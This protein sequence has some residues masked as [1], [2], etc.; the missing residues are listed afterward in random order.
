MSIGTSGTITQ[1]FSDRLTASL[2]MEPS[3]EC[4]FAMLAGAARAGAMGL[5]AAAQRAGGTGANM[6]EAMGNAMGSLRMLDPRL[7]SIAR[8]FTRVVIDPSAAMPGKVI[9]VNRP[10]FVSGTMTEVARRLTEGNQISATPISPSWAQLPLTVREYG[11]VHNGTDAVA[12]IGVSSFLVDRAAHDQL[13][14][15][16]FILRRDFNSWVDHVFSDLLLTSTN[17]EFA[18]TADGSAATDLASGDTFTDVEIRRGVRFMR[19]R[20]IPPFS[21]TGRYLLFITPRI[22][23][24]L[25]GST[26]FREAARYLAASGPLFSG[27]VASWGGCDVVV[28]NA[29]PAS[30]GG[31]TSQ[32][33]THPAIFVGANTPLA[34]GI[35]MDAEVRISKADDFGRE[36]KFAWLQHAAYA[37][38]DARAVQVTHSVV[39]NV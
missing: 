1:E 10:Q 5:P 3:A 12:P 8:E 30:V 39:G 22:E 15:I 27:H 17:V 19:E 20:N 29:M 11:G 35:A 38:L 2:A 31:S 4:V 23:E 32:F 9:L 18:G 26:G 36:L 33:V 28:S 37:L 14:Y 16:G 6:A 13:E 21:A 24:A 34:Y 25:L 7:Q